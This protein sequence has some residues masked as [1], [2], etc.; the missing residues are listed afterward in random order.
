M[1]QIRYPEPVNEHLGCFYL[2]KK[3][4]FRLWAPAAQEVLLYLYERG[5]GG[6]LLERLP[7]EKLAEGIWEYQ[8]MKDGHGL[9]YTYCLR[10]GEDWKEC[11]DPYS[12]AVGCNGNRTMICDLSRTDSLAF[13]R[14]RRVGLEHPTDAV[15]CEL[16]LRD[17]TAGEESGYA[18]KG[19][20]LSFLEEK[21]KNHAGKKTGLAHLKDLGVTHVHLLPVF[22][23]ASIDEDEDNRNPGHQYNW[24][25]DPKNYNVPE[26]SYSTDPYDGLA[27]I[28]EFKQMV[29]MFHR[30]G[31]GVIMDVVYNHTYETDGCF[32]A[33]A[34][35][36]YYRMENGEFTNGSGCGNELASERPMVRKYIV[37]SLCFLA[38]EYHLDGFR[39]DLMAVLDIETMNEIRTRLDEIDPQILLYGEGWNGGPSALY[40]EVAASKDH[41]DRLHRIAVFDDDLRDGIKGDVFIHE[42]AGFVNQ[43]EDTTYLTAGLKR[44]MAGM[45]TDPSKVVQYVSAHD[46]LTLWDK[47]TLSCPGVSKEDRIR[48]NQLAAAMVFLSEGIPFFQAGEEILRSK[49]NPDGTP[50]DNSYNAP[51]SVNAIRWENRTEYESVFRY[52]QGLIAF[53][54]KHDLLRLT[55]KS[56]VDE[57]MHFLTDEEL[58]EDC[59]NLIAFSLKNP[60]E[61]VGETVLAYFNANRTPMEV[62]L[63]KGKWKVYVD[64]G[65]AGIVPL[66]SIRSKSEPL[67]LPAISATV[68]VKKG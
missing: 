26:G 59:G 66:R 44:A 13:L 38:K 5:D 11:A 12:R 10:Y 64:E 21:T 58:P 52:Y 16:H 40:P 17:F 46:N 68:L 43:P 48:M 60:H 27:R 6:R 22:D 67:T 2:G 28:R 49:T 1:D 57:A 36:Y 56:K 32:E 65:A 15:I 25:Y 31:I 7:M 35:G 55:D 63:P 39:F 47:L 4:T 30:N 14:D 50:N 19:K 62:T 20:Y 29:R 3:T 42:H 54:K 53:R 8:L 51:D 37:E 45:G 23:F 33:T 41:V 61:P 18:L 9:Y 24:G 34:P